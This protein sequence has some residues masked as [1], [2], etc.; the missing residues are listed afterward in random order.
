MTKAFS[1]SFWKGGPQKGV[2]KSPPSQLGG[3]RVLTSDSFAWL[4]LLTAPAV[5]VN[6]SPWQCHRG[7]LSSWRWTQR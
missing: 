2:K 7:L 4:V 5:P 3:P 6:R 1:L